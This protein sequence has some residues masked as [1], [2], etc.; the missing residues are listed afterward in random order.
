MTAIVSVLNAQGIAIAADSAVTVSSGE[1]KKVYNKS[2][3]L[4][5]LSK[6]H[7]VGIAIYNSA[8][9]MSIPW[10]TLIKL[11]RKQLK[12]KKFDTIE[13]YKLDFLSFL[14]KNLDFITP[15]IKENSFYAFCHTGY[16]EVSANIN[17]VL[18]DNN[19]LIQGMNTSD[20]A[21]YVATV[22]SQEI[23]KYI[24][25]LNS[26][27]QNN[28]IKLLLNDF[29]REYS[30]ELNEIATS[31]QDEIKK[32]SETFTLNTADS[33]LF[34][35]IF[36]HL[37]KIDNFIEQSSGLIFM[38]FGEKEVYP[39][40]QLVTV[41][42][43]IGNNIR[44][45]IEDPIYISP[46]TRDADIIPYAQRDVTLAVLTGIDPKYDDEISGAVRESFKSISEEIKNK[47]QDQTIANDIASVV[48]GVPQVLIDKLNKY[49]NEKITGPLI[50][51]LVNMGKEDMA[52]MAESLVNITSL[53][54]KFTM[55]SSDESVGGPVDVAIITKG[56]GFIWLKRKNYFE[57][58]LNRGFID[59]Y[60]K[61]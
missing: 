10:E 60:Y 4:F 11:Y 35:E 48:D 25:Y 15:K 46:G 8:H 42:M 19:L 1:V 22:V 30:T 3:K 29:K 59:K 23:P 38:G 53:K 33:D 37:A 24:T 32:K 21:N 34:K 12:E 40:S 7:P 49:R 16:N 28:T 44:Y 57:Y 39:S 45:R 51:V 31:F 50:N 2:N 43:M 47:I 27:K 18:D 14:T 9:F 58:G 52:E 55:N 54:R 13:K 61:D 20:A 26:L 5:T 6:F 17:K 41:G 56:D 36:F